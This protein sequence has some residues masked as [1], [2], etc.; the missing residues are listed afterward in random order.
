MGKYVLKR[1]LI[2]IPVLLGVTLLVFT[3]L[4][5]AKGDPARAKLGG[6]ATEEE[7]QELRE[8]WGL[9]DSYI[10]RY[11]KYI[12]NIVFHFDFGKSYAT[13]KSVSEEI[14]SRF[15]MTLQLALVSV[16]LAL[17]FG[18]LMGIIAAVKQFSA[19]DH[20]SMV[21]ALIGS[22]MPAFWVGL[23]MSLLFAL[24]LKWLPASGW[25][26]P[27]QMIMPCIA[28]AIGH[29]GGVARQT[30]S[31]MLEVIRQDYITTAKAKGLSNFK[32]IFV[33][34]FRNALLPIITAAGNILGGSL[35]GAV[36]IETVFSIPGLGMYMVDAI[37]RR[38]YPAIQGSTLF[39]AVIF[40][41]VMLLV[42]I[43]YAFADPR[44]KARYKKS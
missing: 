2:M 11:V 43:L 34:A 17:F 7:V 8:E 37:N 5:F 6:D 27:E 38:D 24:K 18:I 16:A 13:G 3:L 4:F 40:G 44:I 28:A 35:G 10:V 14:L 30:R 29:A 33:H 19:I 22:S 36:I 32:V 39:L 26:T 31:S 42:D 23:M 21:A 15:G 25:G 9:N 1:I 41:L 20:I 12:K